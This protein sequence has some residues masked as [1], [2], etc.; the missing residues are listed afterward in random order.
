MIPRNGPKAKAFV[1]AARSGKD[2][3]DGTSSANPVTQPGQLLKA[4]V[5]R[6][7]AAVRPGG[8]NVYEDARGGSYKATPY[9]Q[10]IARPSVAAMERRPARRHA[11]TAR[12]IL[13][14]SKRK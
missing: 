8:G 14:M 4:L 9:P 13:K 11:A 2:N 10:R 7:A 6:N 3:D 12:Q 1:Q 5:M